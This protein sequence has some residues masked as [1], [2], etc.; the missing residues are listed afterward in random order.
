MNREQVFDKISD[1]LEM[2]KFSHT[3]FAFPFALLGVVLASQA[4]H[5]LPGFGQIFWICLAMRM[6]IPL[7]PIRTGRLHTNCIV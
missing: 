6:N 4:N 3:I 1:L 2:I 7:K 5:A